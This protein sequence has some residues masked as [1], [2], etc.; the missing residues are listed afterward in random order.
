MMKDCC[1]DGETVL[2]HCPAQSP[3]PVPPPVAQFICVGGG[4]FMPDAQVDGSTCLDKITETGLGNMIA[5][6]EQDCNME[7]P[8]EDGMQV[9]HGLMY[10]QYTCCEGGTPTTQGLCG[11]NFPDGNVCADSGKFLPTKGIDD[12]HCQGDERM[13]DPRDCEYE[14]ESGWDDSEEEKCDVGRMN[15]PDD[16]KAKACERMGGSWVKHK[17]FET[18]MWFMEMMAGKS[19]TDMSWCSEQ[20]TRYMIGMMKDCC[21]DGETVLTHCPAP[22]PSPMM[23]G[24]C[25]NM[26]KY[27]PNAR[28]GNMY[29]EGAQYITNKEHCMPFGNLD[30]WDEMADQKCDINLMTDETMK[31]GACAEIGGTWQG[32]DCATMAMWVQSG[33]MCAF[34]GFAGWYN[35][36]I[37]PSCCSGTEIN[38]AKCDPDDK[39]DDN[40]N[41]CARVSAQAIRTARMKG[42]EPKFCN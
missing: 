17:C 15:L 3:T 36:L 11:D 13:P 40:H 38:E 25:K 41:G 20:D 31:A 7:L 6:T 21:E 32:R 5:F 42:Y 2:T 24:M 16:K 18:N 35:S 33:M 1:E 12:F 19:A 9:K 8:G 14:G 10:L 28:T 37:A 34:E 30:A 23:D 39:P 4:Q 29:C 27:D 22:A 26:E